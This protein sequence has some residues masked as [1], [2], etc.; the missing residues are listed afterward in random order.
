MRRL[1]SSSRAVSVASKGID[2][3]SGREILS[4]ATA[5]VAGLLPGTPCVMAVTRPSTLAPSGRTV[6]P[7]TDTERKT[8]AVKGSPTRDEYE[9]KS[10]SIRSGMTVP[11]AT[12][13]DFWLNA[14]AADA[15]ISI[16]DRKTVISR[17]T[18]ASFTS[19]VLD[20]KLV[21]VFLPGLHIAFLSGL[22]IAEA[23]FVMFLIT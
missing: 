15:R 22:D 11:T 14:G 3:P 4:K 2:F 21:I 7:S 16:S 8:V 9:L 23:S 17:S 20:R 19:M 10:L 13:T 1:A 12:L 18:A 5:I 6:R